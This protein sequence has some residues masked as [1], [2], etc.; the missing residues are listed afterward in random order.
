MIETLR[1]VQRV[2]E[3]WGRKSE[4][5][6]PIIR[7]ELSPQHSLGTNAIRLTTHGTDGT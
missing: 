3:T 7:D 1:P 6:V 5:V 2:E 4:Y